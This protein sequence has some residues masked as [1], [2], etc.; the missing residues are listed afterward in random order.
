[1][2]NNEMKTSLKWRYGAIFTHLSECEIEKE[3]KKEKVKTFKKNSYG[4][5]GCGNLE[6]DKLCVK[7]MW[8]ISEWVE[9]DSLSRE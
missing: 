8:H 4:Y 7:L 3:G 2:K 6:C 1:M 5:K 9:A